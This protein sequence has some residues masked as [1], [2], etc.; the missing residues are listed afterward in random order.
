MLKPADFSALPSA[1]WT[2]LVSVTQM[3]FFSPSELGF[4]NIRNWASINEWQFFHLE[5]EAS[6]H[7]AEPG[8]SQKGKRGKP[9]FLSFSV[10]FPERCGSVLVCVSFEV[11][12]GSIAFRLCSLGGI[13]WLCSTLLPHAR[14]GGICQWSLCRGFRTGPELDTS[15]LSSTFRCCN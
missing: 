2:A 5:Y 10:L 13:G 9:G 7:P 12:C 14:H 4:K 11:L 6:P 15:S 8:F 1:S 3:D